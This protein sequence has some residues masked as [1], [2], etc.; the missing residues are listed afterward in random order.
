MNHQLRAKLLHLLEHGRLPES[1]VPKRFLEWTNSLQATGVLR[2]ERTAR[3]KGRQ[4]VVADRSAL[5]RFKDREF[6]TT[7]ADPTLGSRVA[8]VAQYRD[9]KAIKNTAPEPLLMRVNAQS[10][11]ATGKTGCDPVDITREHGVFAALLNGSGQPRPMGRWVVI[12][13]PSVFHQHERLFGADSSAVLTNGR[14]SNKVLAWLGECTGPDV[15]LIHAPDYDPAGMSDHRRLYE[16]VGSAVKL[17]L[18]DHIEDLFERYSNR[19]LL[20]KGRQQA[21][22]RELATFEHGDVTRLC[23]LMRKYN[24]GLEQEALLADV[25]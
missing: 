8:S 14:I 11:L 10:P 13:N 24:A 21:M 2:M 12:E 17:H 19:G 1:Q 3:A 20:M 4:L 9:T 18:P 23:Q 7:S 16:Q 5:E 15:E 6:P 22:L 25:I